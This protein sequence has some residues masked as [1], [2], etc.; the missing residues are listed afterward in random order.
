MRYLVPLDGSKLAEQAL[1]FAKERAAANNGDIV[2]MRVV[3]I[4]ARMP[5]SAMAD[6][7][8]GGLSVAGV[9]ALQD[10]AEEESRKAAEYLEKQAQLLR[11]QGLKVTTAVRTGTPASE[12]IA[13]AKERSV[14]VIIITTHG[15]SGLGRLV[16]GSVADE[17]I[18]GGHFPVLVINNK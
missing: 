17:V 13:T 9:E 6:G 8:M 11:Q 14:D 16:F 3:D 5:P 12:I 1:P 18:R 10:A 15:R 4:A 7:G 2:L